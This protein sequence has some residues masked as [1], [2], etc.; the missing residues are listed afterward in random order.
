[1]LP[2]VKGMREDAGDDNVFAYWEL[3]NNELEKYAKNPDH[4]RHK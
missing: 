3:L 2:I 4:S 1:M